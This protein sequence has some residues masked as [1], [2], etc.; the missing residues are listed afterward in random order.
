[1][2]FV[3]TL[4]VW[5]ILMVVESLHG[6]F[7]RLVLEPSVGDLR[8]RQFAVF[9]GSALILLVTY[10]FIVWIDARTSRQLTVVGLVWVLLTSLFEVGI[11]RVV[12]DY[13]WSRVLADFDITRGGL[14]GLGMVFL[15]AVP[16]LAARLRHAQ[17]P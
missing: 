12:L 6:V 7:R 3:R 13:S 15:A 2:W 4:A 11:G 14:L 9:S 17:N 16:Q 5:L 1:M 8:A 10:L